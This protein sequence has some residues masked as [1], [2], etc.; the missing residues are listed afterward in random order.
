MD[1][2][3]DIGGVGEAERE[4]ETVC[5]LA[6]VGIGIVKFCLINFLGAEESITLRDRCRRRVQLY[7][8]K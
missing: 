3:C 7:V 5:D 6:R 4:G 8:K 2:I 1:C